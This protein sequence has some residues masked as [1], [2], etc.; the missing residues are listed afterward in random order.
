ML[1]NHSPSEYF[2]DPKIIELV[3]A[4]SC[5]DTKKI[6]TLASLSV[7]LNT[8]GID[9]TT[10]LGWAREVGSKNGMIA[11]LNAGANP[12]LET[13]DIDY[14]PIVLA[15]E[16][17]IPDY[18][19]IILSHGGNPNFKGKYGNSLLHYGI[20]KIKNVEILIKAGADINI[21]NDRGETPLIEAAVSS[22][23]EAILYL[24][25]EGADY[26]MHDIA[27]ITFFN[28]FFR[29]PI[30]F[31]NPYQKSERQKVINYLKLHG[32]TEENYKKIIKK[33]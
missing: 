2:K 16:A 30:I 28:Y 24:L 25:N 3:E 13:P 4:A 19:E 32:I 6:Q 23:Y 20:S 12:N 21:K 26:K 14:S 29:K 11:L 7:N 18:L 15:A 5:G 9:N 1:D 22:N 8:I 27:N 31:I 33:T 10:A 17:N